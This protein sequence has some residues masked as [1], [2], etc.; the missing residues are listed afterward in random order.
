MHNILHESDSNGVAA[1][2]VE[3]LG[4]GHEECILPWL[5]R[6]KAHSIL[7]LSLIHELIT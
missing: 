3:A 1:E 6:N 7:L 4:L 2:A 5:L